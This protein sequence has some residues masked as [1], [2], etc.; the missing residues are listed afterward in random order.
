MVFLL[1]SSFC[2]FDKFLVSV[3]SIIIVPLD[4]LSRRANK[5]SNDD[6]PEPEGPTRATNSPSL[7]F[8]LKL[9]NK[10]IDR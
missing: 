8:I 10:D 3:L 1:S 6:L 4:G 7:I 9:L 2:P 5:C